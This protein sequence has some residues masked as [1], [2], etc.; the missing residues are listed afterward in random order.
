MRGCGVLNFDF[1]QGQGKSTM[2]MGDKNATFWISGKKVRIM[3]VYWKKMEFVREM[4]FVKML[5]H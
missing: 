1:I 4:L 5:C 3:S 2:W